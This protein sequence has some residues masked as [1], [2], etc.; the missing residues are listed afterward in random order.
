MTERTTSPLARM[1]ETWSGWRITRN[2]PGVAPEPGFTAVER[3]T[4][5]RITAT[6][7]TEMEA[8]LTAEGETG[9]R[10]GQ[11]LPQGDNG[12]LGADGQDVTATALTRGGELR[13][14][15]HDGG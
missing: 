9:S 13:Q 3:A 14:A 12:N 6:T 4:G 15:G 8:L 7:L 1:Q 11:R 10:I 2:I 5:R